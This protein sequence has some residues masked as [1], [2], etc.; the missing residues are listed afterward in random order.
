ML[1]VKF[2]KKERKNFFDMKHKTF[3]IALE[4]LVYTIFRKET[5]KNETKIEFLNCLRMNF[6]FHW[7][8]DWLNEWMDEDDDGGKKNFD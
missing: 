8:T 5:R 2:Q 3:I 7:M 6:F 1:N 4:T